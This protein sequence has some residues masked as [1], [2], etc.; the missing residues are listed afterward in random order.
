MKKPSSLSEIRAA[1]G[2]K[3]GSVSSAAKTIAAR[4]NGAIGGSATSDAKAEAARING[5]EGGR[6]RRTQ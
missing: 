5:R 6:P 2:R 4:L 1:A 3:G